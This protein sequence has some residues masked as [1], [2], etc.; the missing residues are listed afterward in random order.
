MKYDNLGRS[1]TA[2]KPPWGDRGG[3]LELSCESRPT[4]L[5]Q[6]VPV[7]EG[8][9]SPSPLGQAPSPDDNESVTT[10]AVGAHRETRI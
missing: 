4:I 10:V 9:R 3:Q 7:R 5:D 1:E 8:S 6:T 2:I